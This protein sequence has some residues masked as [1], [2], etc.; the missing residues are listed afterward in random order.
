MAP[1]VA[2]L[3]TDLWIECLSFLSHADLARAL[4]TCQALSK[5]SVRAWRASCFRHWP[6]WASIAEL[7]DCDW[8]RVTEFC[9]LRESERAVVIDPSAVLQHQDIIEDRHR[10]ILAE[11]MCEVRLVDN[12]R[13][14]GPIDCLTFHDLS[15]FVLSLSF[16]V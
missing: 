8:R 1:G 13:H 2:A 14:S 6:R 11:W 15:F 5:E 10:A 7:S 16:H 12:S 4:C 9:C 3:P